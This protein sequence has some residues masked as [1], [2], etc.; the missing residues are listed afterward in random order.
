MH[1]HGPQAR[2]QVGH[3]LFGAFLVEPPGS[4]YFDK[5]SGAALYMGPVAGEQSYRSSWDAIISPGDGSADFR[6]F[7]LF[8]HEIG[9]AKFTPEDKVGIPNPIIDPLVNSYKPNGRAINYRSES[10]WRRLSASN[11][12]VGIMDEAEAY[13]TYAFGEPAMPVPQTY[14][15]DPIKFRLLHA[16]SETVHVP[17][18]HGGGIQWQ[19]QQD[20]GKDGASDYTPIDAGLKKEFEASMPSS[21]NDSQSIAPSETYELEIACGSGGCQQ[22]A[23]DFLFHCHVASHY[24]SGMWHF[25]RVYNTRQALPAEKTDELALVAE[26]PD[27]AGGM[28]SAVSSPELIGQN[29]TF[30]GQS[31]TVNSE[32]LADLVESQLPPAGEP[33]HLMDAAVWNWD[34]QGDL[35]LGEPDS[36][37]V[38]PNYAARDPGAR[39]A[40]MFDPATGKLAFPHLKPHLGQRPPFAPNHGPAPFLEPLDHDRGQP[41]APGANGPTSLCPAGAPVR[42]YKVHAIQTEIPVTSSQTDNDGMIFVV[43]EYED[44]A[45]GDPYFK[46]PLAIRAN[47]GDCVDIILVNELEDTGDPGELSKTNIHIHFVQFD[48]QASDGVISGASYEQAPRPFLDPGMSAVS[49]SDVPIG[50]TWITVVDASS[51]HIGSVVG[52]GMDQQLSGFETAVIAD[53][54]GNTL[55]FEQ[56]LESSHATGERV[57][58]EFVRYRWFV[59][60]QNG[61]IY[62]HDHV[63]ALKRW[64]HGLF[65]ALIAEPRNS[66]WH[67]PISGEPILSGTAADIRLPQDQEVLPGL[68]GSFREFVMFMTDHNPLTG[69]AF[70]L[71]AEPLFGETP[72]G[73]GPPEL[74][75]SSVMYGDP[76]TPV[77]R[78]YVGDPVILRLLTTAAEEVH[79]FHITGHTFRQERFQANSPGITVFGVGI[80][81]RFNAFLGLAGGLGGMPGD[82]FYYN[83]AQRHFLEG[84][85]GIFR[86]HD[87][88]QSDLQPLPDLEPESGSGFPRLTETGTAPVQANST[89]NPCP[90]NASGERRLFISAIDIPL[91]FNPDLGLGIPGGR[92]YVLT[93]DVR[94]IHSGEKLPEPLVVRANAGECINVTFSN[95][96]SQPASFHLDALAFDPRS[97]LGINLGFNQGQVALPGSFQEYRYYAGQEMGAV[98]IRDFG[99]PFRNAREGRYGALIVEPAGSTYLDPYSDA[100]LGSGVAAVIQQPDGSY[101]REFV[102]LFHDADP[103]IGLFVMPYDEEVNRTVGV[104]YRVEPFSLRMANFG[105]LLDA[106]PIAFED[107][108]LARN[109]FNATVFGDPWTHVFEAF[110]GEAFRFR[111]LSGYSEQ[112]QVFSLEGHQWALTPELTGSDSVSSR[113]LPPTG[114]LNIEIDQSGGPR[115][116]PGDYLWSNHRLPYLKAGMWGIFRVL[117]PD[118][119]TDLAIP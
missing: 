117:G 67:D 20:M 42:T 54:D 19:R 14:L 18:L 100:P 30:A 89:G 83:G 40:L 61:A 107:R 29:V 72:R 59:A 98:L 70:N 118:A 11:E 64:G 5:R 9:N 39:P 60:R 115:S 8:Y 57:S 17:H 56:P 27:R 82:Y 12:A 101:F 97:S 86:V 58:V 77:L 7:S 93:E 51:F 1:S 21:G 90:A 114:V 108:P 33:K 50:S 88:L 73:S 81:E 37:L 85:W 38:W 63:D 23:G 47:Q 65:G 110:A 74:A 45:R 84:S 91:V 87:T 6:E 4:A 53:I 41:A 28:A 94:A 78:A 71:R 76:H 49:V 24:I 34:K 16:G 43:K 99:N 79:P 22:T 80:S 68:E 104:N 112:S 62:F 48:T 95:Q 36:A 10:F 3:G 26:L 69:S 66:T 32:N 111:V 52:L 103:D 102:L 92:L 44:L 25:W 13:S 106:D 96:S 2:Y 31:L 113:Y 55:F 105:V 116:Q 46:T 109:I 35:Y 75:F 15:G 119:I